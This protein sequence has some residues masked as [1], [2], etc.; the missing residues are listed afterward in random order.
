[1]A[2]GVEARRL[3]RDERGWTQRIVVAGAQ[4]AYDLSIMA[5]F[6]RASSPEPERT[7]RSDEA[8]AV[9]QQFPG[10]RAQAVAEGRADREAG[11]VYDGEAVERWMA[12]WEAEVETDLPP[13]LR[14]SRPQPGSGSGL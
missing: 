8:A 10:S 3:G 1:M 2:G 6:K 7:R 14:L 12:D 5:D 13:A 4:D 11:R 9:A